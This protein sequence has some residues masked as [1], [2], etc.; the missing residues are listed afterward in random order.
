LTVVGWPCSVAKITSNV[1][2]VR[3]A[4]VVI[5]AK[6]VEDAMPPS[7]P[8]IWI[9]G[10]PDSKVRFKELEVIRGQDV[11]GLVLPGYL[12]QR[13]DFNDQQLPYTFVRPG[14]R[15]GSCFANSYRQGAEFLLFLKKTKTGEL[16]VNWAPLAPVNEELRPSEDRWLTWVREQ[17]QKLEKHLT[18]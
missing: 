1:D 6:A 14:G 7:D 17:A 13:D 8:D 15:G 10:V 2:L 5:R 18:K 3:N 12:V 4:D 9:N 16:T 11:S